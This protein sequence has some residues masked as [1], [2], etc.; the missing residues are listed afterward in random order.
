MKTCSKCGEEKPVEAFSKDSSRK[1]GL[2]PACKE[3]HLAYS[4]AVSK[5][6][7]AAYQK[8]YHLDHIEHRRE[9]SRRGYQE[10]KATRAVQIVAWQKEN[11]EAYKLIQRRS[12]HK[13]KEYGITPEKFD[14]YVASIHSVCE[15]CGEQK[16]LVVDHCHETKTFRGALCNPCNSALGLLQNSG[17]NGINLAAYLNRPAL[18]L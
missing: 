16:K 1:S 17:Q 13:H 15:I 7:K 4:N 12:Q 18:L 3:C 6:K 8:Q 9:N 2:Q 10:N 5:E 14:A 11:P